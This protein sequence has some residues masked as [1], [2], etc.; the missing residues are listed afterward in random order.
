MSST[1]TTLDF[2][3]DEIF[4]QISS[5]A[6]QKNIESDDDLPATSVLR[7]CRKWLEIGLPLFWTDVVLSPFAFIKFIEAPG[8]SPKNLRKIRSL[9]LITTKSKAM[10]PLP[11]D[12]DRHAPSLEAFLLISSD[13]YAQ[14]LNCSMSCDSCFLSS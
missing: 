4:K 11:N 9:T 13:F 1:R 7:V 10:L 6:L 8:S 12:R 2:F 5:K 3:P 14:L